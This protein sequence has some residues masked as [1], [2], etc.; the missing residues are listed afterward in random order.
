[1]GTDGFEEGKERAIRTT[2]AGLR[3]E[4]YGK[5]VELEV[6][7]SGQSSAKNLPRGLQVTKRAGDITVG[8]DGYDFTDEEHFGILRGFLFDQAGMREKFSGK[9]NTVKIREDG[10]ID[11]QVLLC[12]DL[13]SAGRQEHAVYNT[14]P[15][16][17]IGAKAPPERRVKVTG[18]VVDDKDRNLVVFAYS[19]KPI[20]ERR[21]MRFGEADHN[22]FGHYFAGS[23]DIEH[24]MDR[25]ICPYVVGRTGAKLATA[26]TLCS[27]ASF[28]FE[29]QRIRGNLHTMFLGETTLGKSRIL[30]WVRDELKLGE[31]GVGDM[32]SYAGLLAAVDAEHDIIIWGLLPL[33]DRE[34]ALID[35]FQKLS[36]DDV[37]MFREA[38]RDER[39]T[40][41]KKV[42]GEAMCRARVLAAANPRRTFDNYVTAAEALNDIASI[43]DPVDLTRWDIFVKFHGRDVADERIAEAHAEE[44]YIPLKV[45]R[46][47][48]LWV[49]SLEAEDVE[50]T[51]EA[52]EAIRQKFVEFS[53]FYCSDLPLVHKGYKETMARVAAAFAALKYSVQNDTGKRRLVVKKEHVES[54]CDFLSRLAEE[55]EY[56]KFAEHS[57][58]AAKL[59]S[60][61]AEEIRTAIQ[62]NQNAQQALDAIAC[63]QGIEA[64]TLAARLGLSRPAV[65]K[66][67][68]L[69]KSFDIVETQRKRPGYWLT[70]K[71]VAFAKLAGAPV[72]PAP[73]Q[74]DKFKRV[75]DIIAE[76]DAG[77][78][79]PINQ[80]AEKAAAGGISQEFVDNLIEQ[81]KQRG[82]LFEPSLGKIAKVRK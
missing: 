75:M 58:K 67:V 47:F 42:S 57:M 45:F 24:D 71:G 28:F 2:L 59:E 64:E 60:A 70:P 41:R 73:Q 7:V 38:L 4:L 72:K 11:Y 31:F 12:R 68:A 6:L 65:T 3:A 46:R 10:R 78:G 35:S 27:P 13:P 76:L 32:A 55:W 15:V 17:L 5:P 48:V 81:G 1:M 22:L 34:V 79:A 16:H 69:L 8:G 9:G 23:G 52:V 20:D 53:A 74:Q 21:E 25:T 61:E 80:V 18:R 82:H 50:F 19:C 33:A 63:S 26:L 43:T 40:V 54:A 56:R 62:D 66:A 44:P 37:P 36:S 51:E 39:I 77:E 29:G 14:V 49:W 30:K